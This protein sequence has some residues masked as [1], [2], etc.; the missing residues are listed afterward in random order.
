MGSAR[1]ALA[2]IAL[3]ALFWPLALAQA[4][5]PEAAAFALS[6]RCPPGFEQLDDG[7]CRL[8]TIYDQYDSLYGRG[9]RG[10]PTALPAG[11][12]RFTPE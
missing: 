1:A 5:T 10:P 6:E 9:V 11:R 7:T 3:T 8:H 4:E 2:G 12:H